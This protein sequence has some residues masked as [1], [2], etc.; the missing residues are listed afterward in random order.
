MTAAD[1]EIWI[2]ADTNRDGRIDEA[3]EA[4]KTEWTSSRGAILLANLDDDGERFMARAPD[5]RHLTDVELAS[6]NDASDEVVN[7]DNDVEDLAKLLARIPT[8]ARSASVR[9]DANAHDRVRLFIAEDDGTS[10]S[11]WSVLPPDGSLRP[12]QWASGVTLLGIEGRDIVRDASW[13]GRCRVTLAVECADGRRVTDSVVLKVA[14]LLF[15]HDLLPLKILYGVD[16]TTSVFPNE[17]A[18]PVGEDD[19]RVRAIK[20]RIERTQ[21]RFRQ[22]VLAGLAR[23]GLGS[24][25]FRLL[26]NLD[27]RAGDPELDAQIQRTVDS[28]D[29]SLGQTGVDIWPQDIMQPAFMSMP[30]PGGQHVMW[31]WLR[32]SARN[33]KRDRD[34]N[35]LRYTSRVVFTELLGPGCAGVQHFDPEYLPQDNRGK[36]GPYSSFDMGGNYAAVPPYTHNGRYYPQ[37]RKLV[38]AAPGYAA[39]PAFNAML[40]AQGYQRPIYVD[41]GWLEVGHVDE[42]VA[43]VESDTERGWAMLAADPELALELLRGEVDRGNGGSPLVSRQEVAP[44]LRDPTLT[45]ADAVASEGVVRGTAKAVAGIDKAVATLANEIGLA[46]VDIVRLPVLF[47]LSLKDLDD[48]PVEPLLPNAVNLVNTGRKLVLA[49]HQHGPVGPDG[50]IFEAAVEQRLWA[51][52]ITVHWVEDLGYAHP[53]GEVHCATNVRR[54]LRGADPW[55]LEGPLTV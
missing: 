32:S 7:G 41:T 13:D 9:I 55:W 8:D 45:I 46:D 29:G 38:G 36:A 25:A 33:P 15:V 39:D 49:A 17:A 40:D 2:R 31:V 30:A 43:F 44:G 3:D 18:F 28:T 16:N 14:P 12:D 42:F 4:G 50:D 11:D 37:G 20:D 48:R 5:G 1:T 19:A 34:V 10:A 23:A 24:D 21:R 51:L 54:D 22:G 27:F 26:P 52:G 47:R 35:P 53:G 6:C